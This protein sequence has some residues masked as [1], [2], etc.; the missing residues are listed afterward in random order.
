MNIYRQEFN[1]SY[2]V[3]VDDQ[4]NDKEP[5]GSQEWLVGMSICVCVHLC[6]CLCVVL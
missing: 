5:K 4:A 3:T 1:C 6:V 2:K